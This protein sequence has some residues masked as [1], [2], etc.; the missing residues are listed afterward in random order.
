MM[1]GCG[2]GFQPGQPQHGMDAVAA[3]HLGGRLQRPADGRPLGLAEQAAAACTVEL[4][5]GLAGGFAPGHAG[6]R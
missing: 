1:P 6:D 3:A 5:A 4:D 2:G